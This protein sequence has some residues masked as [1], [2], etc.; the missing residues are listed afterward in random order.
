MLLQLFDPSIRM[1][2]EVT[3]S[4]VLPVAFDP[5]QFA[6]VT[7]NI[8]A[9]ANHAMPD[10]GRFDIEVRPRESAVDIVFTDSG[11]GVAPGLHERIFEP[12][13]TTKPNGQG[14]GL[15]LAVAANLV[16]SAGGTLSVE[17]EPGAGARFRMRL[18]RAAIAAA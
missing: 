11:P 5:A 16:R 1:R 15:G 2:I 9:N 10:G 4:E 8:A 13:F 7:L 17:S 6:L 18:P 14:T 3:E 12:F